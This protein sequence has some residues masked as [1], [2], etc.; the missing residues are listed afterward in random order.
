MKSEQE[1]GIKIKEMT[2]LYN[3]AT[4]WQRDTISGFLEALKWTLKEEEK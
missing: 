3:H 2:D 1:I 4:G